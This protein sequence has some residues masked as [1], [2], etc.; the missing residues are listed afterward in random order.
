MAS[1]DAGSLARHRRRGPWP[2]DVP[3]RITRFTL[4]M[5]A[6]SLLAMLPGIPAAKDLVRWTG[7]R[8]ALGPM[9]QAVLSGLTLLTILGVAAMHE[10]L[11]VAAAMLM[12]RRVRVGVRWNAGP[13]V[14]VPERLPRG[15]ALLL[16]LMP[17][18]AG[19]PLLLAAALLWPG[20]GWWLAFAM[21]VNWASGVGDYAN[22]AVLLALPRGAIVV[23][24]EGDADGIWL[25]HTGE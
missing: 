7:I 15:E 5:A 23:T 19:T 10:L 2:F 24:G 25:P 14:E 8:I 6:L 9:P 17:A 18:L 16:N 13:Y 1:G 11:H 12:G 3:E 21:A 20:A 4:I 22:A